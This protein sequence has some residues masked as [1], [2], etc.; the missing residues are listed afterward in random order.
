MLPGQSTTQRPDLVARVFHLKFESLL[1][2]IMKKDIFGEAVAY[3]FTVEYQKRGLP[4]V[5]LVLFLARSSRLS[6]P[7]AVDKYISTEIPDEH[8]QP[9]LF[10]LIKQFMIHGPCGPGISSPCMNNNKCT[11]L[12]PKPFRARTEITGDSL[13]HT[14]RRDDG[15][16]IRVGAHYVDNRSVVSYSPYLT[17]RYE[18]PINVEC[19]SGFHAVKYIYKVRHLVQRFYCSTVFYNTL[20]TFTKAPIARV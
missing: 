18:A 2:E 8:D 14:R 15:R 7:E 1:D 13:V 6:T 19:T 16:F 5:H 11:K 3:A 4:H 20:S 17:L 9:R 10:N 12:F